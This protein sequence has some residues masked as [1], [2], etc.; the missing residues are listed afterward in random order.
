MST[1]TRSHGWPT[2]D[3]CNGTWCRT[4]PRW[5][6]AQGSHRL[7]NCSKFDDQVG[8]WARDW[9]AIAVHRRPRCPQV[10]PPCAT[11]R[12]SSL[13][14]FGKIVCYRSLR[15]S[16]ASKRL[17]NSPSLMARRGQ[18]PHNVFASADSKHTD[19]QGG[20]SGPLS[21]ALIMTSISASLRCSANLWTMAV[22]YGLQG[23]LQ[24][25]SDLWFRWVGCPCCRSEGSL[26]ALPWHK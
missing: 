20:F 5:Y 26:P 21:N 1:D 18:I 3:V 24:L 11:C 9:T 2:S 6:C 8:Q 15:P 10:I 12:N 17:F 16:G 23:P 25:R 19:S 13:N 14:T 4:A 7:T 22:S